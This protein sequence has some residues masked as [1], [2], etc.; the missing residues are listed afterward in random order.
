MINAALLVTLLYML[1]MQCSKAQKPAAANPS[2]L[3]PGFT[4]TYLGDPR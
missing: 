3:E 1:P 2:R 4:L